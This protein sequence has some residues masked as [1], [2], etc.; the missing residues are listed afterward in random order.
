MISERLLVSS[1]YLNGF[2]C[3]ADCGTDHGYLPIYAVEKGLVKHAYASD[4]KKYPLEN[5]RR[6]VEQ[7]YLEEQ[8]T[9]VLA[10]GLPYLNPEID[11][12]SILGLG[13]RSIATIIKEAN[14]TYLKRLVL[15]PNSEA[16]FLRSFLQDNQWQIIA[17]EF[18]KDKGKFYPIIIV[19][20]GKMSLT[21][22]ELEFGPYILQ[23]RPIAFLEY[24]SRFIQTLEAAV[25]NIQNEEEREKLTQRITTLKEVLE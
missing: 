14:T 7:S 9:L 15:S 20:K 19:E 16:M 22:T 17:E 21:E 2:H 12:V 8:I 18:L 6:N 11:I 3:L 23:N 5:A 25:L 13:G 1:K 4:N 24:L 10:D